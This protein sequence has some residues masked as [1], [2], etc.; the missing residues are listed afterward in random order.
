VN[1]PDAVN[2]DLVALLAD[3]F[4]DKC[5]TET[6][7]A[8]EG[9]WS[10]DLWASLDELG[11]T[12]VGVDEEAGGSGGGLRDAL[13]IVRVAAGYAAPV[14]LAHTL[15]VGPESR[16]RFEL[17]HRPGATAVALYG[18]LAVEETAEGGVVRGSIES[19]PYARQAQN[20]IVV[21]ENG[22]QDVAVEL[23]ASVLSWTERTNVAGEPRADAAISVHVDQVAHGIAPAGTRETVRDAEA[24]A[25]SWA[26]V[27]A[28][29]KV[30]ELVTTYTRQREQFGRPLSSFQ[31]VKQLAAVVAGE[32]SVAT[33]A[34][35]AAAMHFELGGASRFPVAAARV[36]CAA[37]VAPVS[38]HAHQLHGAIGYTREYPLHQFTRRLWA[39]RDEGRTQRQWTQLAGERVLA[40]GAENLWASIA[41]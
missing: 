13:T 19:V 12:A 1:E 34:A 25:Q 33:A 28:M 39:W 32:I 18:R 23:D 38:R 41:S 31:A 9:G 35:S 11:L 3:V 15:V 37:A 24:L 8:A 2:E 17:P 22:D 21:A 14:P 10:Q 20:L 26:L 16:R 6:V 40:A 29:Q 4:A 27:G 5:T 7:E 36:R 30:G